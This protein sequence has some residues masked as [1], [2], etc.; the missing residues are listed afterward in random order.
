M[1]RCKKCGEMV[2]WSN[3]NIHYG[4][5]VCGN[6]RAGYPIS[7]KLQKE[8]KKPTNSDKELETFVAIEKLK[9]K[10]R[11][12]INILSLCDPRENRGKGLVCQFCEA[13][14]KEEHKGWCI[15]LQMT[16]DWQV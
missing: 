10:V 8:T 13:T 7:A 1:S 16:E 12:L 6:P 15:Y 2:D 4:G 14:E 5:H 9:K 3:P 11:M